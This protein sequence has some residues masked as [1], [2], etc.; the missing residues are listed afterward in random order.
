MLLSHEYI[1]SS[2]RA[3]VREDEYRNRILSNEEYQVG[4]QIELDGLTWTIEEIIR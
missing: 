4:D 1:A 2:E 3:S